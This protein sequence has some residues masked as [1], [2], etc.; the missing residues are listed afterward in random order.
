MH[1]FDFSFSTIY[2]VSVFKFLKHIFRSSILSFSGAVPETLCHVVPCRGMLCHV[3]PCCVMCF[4]VHCCAMLWHFVQW[5]GMC[6]F[7]PCCVVLWVVVPWRD[8]CAMLCNVFA[9]LCNVVPCCVMLCRVLQRCAM[10]CHVLCR[11]HI[12]CSWRGKHG[13]CRFSYIR[14]WRALFLDWPQALNLSVNRKSYPTLHHKTD[15]IETEGSSSRSELPLYFKKGKNPPLLFIGIRFLHLLR[16]L[17]VTVCLYR[18][19]S[20]NVSNSP[21]LPSRVLLCRLAQSFL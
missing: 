19:L 4:V 10:M 3:V 1:F 2:K 13:T 6:N 20:G 16:V 17:S 8:F 7:V 9:V 18:G 12:T 21:S 14:R 15:T 5:C 11:V